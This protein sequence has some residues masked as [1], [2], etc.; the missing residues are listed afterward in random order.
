MNKAQQKFGEPIEIVR[1]KV[2]PEM[3]GMVQDFIR[4]APF[5]VL[6]TA[7]AEGD[8]D[9]SPKGGRP[10]FVR[11]VDENR[12]VV[13][14]IAGN[15]LFQSY[16]NF[17]SNPKAGLLFL[18]PGCDWTVRVNG[19]VSVLDADGGRLQGVAPEVFDPDDNTKVLQGILLEVEEALPHCPRAFTF[20]KLWN[21]QSNDATREA[22]PNRYWLG[23]WRDEMAK[24]DAPRLVLEGE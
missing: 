23:R 18:I 3:N 19:R 10:G 5:V 1:K 2:F 14:D 21:T 16:E 20:S 24:T 22:D 8:C 9:A 12:L 11:V 15:K 17:E 4:Q 7:N 6:A 13:P